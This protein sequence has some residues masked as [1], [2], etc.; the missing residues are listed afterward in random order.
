[1]ASSTGNYKE[2]S[3]FSSIVMIFSLLTRKTKPYRRITKQNQSLVLLWCIL[4]QNGY[5]SSVTPSSPA[6]TKGN[7]ERGYSYWPYKY[8]ATSESHILRVLRAPRC[9]GSPL[10]PFDPGTVTR[11]HVL[12]RMMM[13]AV[14]HIW[15]ASPLLTS[16]GEKVI[17]ILLRTSPR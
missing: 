12:L 7:L 2:A 1:M 6:M 14:K 3:F 9:L 10:S 4:K 5:S 13:A 8:W 15:D 11:R 17:K 16:R